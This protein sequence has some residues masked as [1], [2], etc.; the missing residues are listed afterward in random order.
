MIKKWESIT[1][2]NKLDFDV[3]EMGFC[4]VVRFKVMPGFCLAKIGATQAL[5]RLSNIPRKKIC[6]V[7]PRHLNYFENEEKLHKFFSEYRVPRKP[8]GKSQVELFNIDIPYFLSNLPDLTY[9]TEAEKCE[10]VVLPNGGFWYKS[11]K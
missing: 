7:S 1:K 4:Y 3:R 11:Q 10:K 6:Y 8:G 9:E 5:S 2:I